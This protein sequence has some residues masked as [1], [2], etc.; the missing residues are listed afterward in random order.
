MSTTLRV[1]CSP[2]IDIYTLY[3][4]WLI[5][6]CQCYVLLL[7]SASDA[8]DIPAIKESR[9]LDIVLLKLWTLQLQDKLFHSVV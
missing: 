7:A 6:L 9:H 3:I 2:V 8:V 4:E 5:S 1:L